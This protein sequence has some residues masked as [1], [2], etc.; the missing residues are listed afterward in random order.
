MVCPTRSGGAGN[1][2]VHSW[3]KGTHVSGGGSLEDVKI[4]G[5]DVRFSSIAELR[6]GNGFKILEL[7]GAASEA[8]SAYDSGKSLRQAYGIL[9]KQGE[10]VFAIGAEN[11]RN[12]HC[13]DPPL[14]ILRQWL[15]YR[16]NSLSPAGRLAYVQRKFS[17]APGRLCPRHESRRTSLARSRAAA[18]SP[19]LR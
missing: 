10:L 11:R 4:A 2:P 8:T 3:R 16:Q 18:K 17:S 9:F 15:R 7:N 12:G 6:A 5:Y 1:L 13:P 14:E 19:T